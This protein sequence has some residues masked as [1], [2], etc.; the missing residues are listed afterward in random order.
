MRKKTEGM[1]VA[2][3]AARPRAEILEGGLRRLS[4][5]SS[6]RK[7]SIDVCLDGACCLAAAVTQLAEKIGVQCSLLERLREIVHCS[8]VISRG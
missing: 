1:S 8:S 6:L 5:L 3:G 4:Q 2:E 7:G